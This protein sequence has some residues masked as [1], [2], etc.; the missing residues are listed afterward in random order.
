MDASLDIS[1]KSPLHTKLLERLDKRY[2]LSAERMQKLHTQWMKAED[3][4]VAY[5]PTKDVDALRTAKRENSGIQDYTTIILPYSYSMMM[6]AHSYW[7]SVFLGRS[8]IWQ[9]SGR[10]GESEQQTQALEA[11]MDYQVQVGRQMLPYYFWLL[12]A[13]KFGLGV[14]GEYWCEEQ[15]YVSRNVMMPGKTILGMELTKPKAQLQT[16]VIPGYQG[17]KLF[18]IRPYD[19]FPDPRV[20][21]WDMQRGEFV[22]HHNEVGWNEIYRKAQSGEFI[23]GNCDVLKRKLFDGGT[24]GMTGRVEG[25]PRANLPNSTE[26]VLNL[27]DLGDTGPYGLLTQYVDLVPSEWGVGESSYPEKWVFTSAVQGRRATTSAAGNLKVILGAKPL[28]AYHNKFPASIIQMEPDAYALTTRGMPEVTRPLQR[29][30]DWLLNVHMYNVRNALNIQFLL[31]PGRVVMGDFKNP[32][33]GGGIRLKQAAWGTDPRTV[34]AQMPVQDVTRGNIMDMQYLDQFAQKAL[35][36]NDAIMGQINTG[37]RKTA[38]EV[39]SSSTFGVNRQKTVSEF[40]SASGFDPLAELMV[41]DSQQWYQGD[42]K[43]KIVGDLA[44]MAGPSFMSVKPED[45]AGFFNF[46]PVDGTLP[47]DRFAQ[48]NLWKEIMLAMKQMPQLAMEYDLGKIFAWTAQLAGLKNINQMKL[49]MQSADP[50]KIAA[51]AQAGNIVPLNQATATNLNEPAQI[52]GMG[53]TG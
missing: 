8:P 40:F 46:V 23:K 24:Q 4:F 42:Q 52:P 38:A 17:C 35:G 19:Y 16:E 49:N 51:A 32:L 20:P 33:P 7:T 21:L 36:I 50:N 31:D 37:G 13:A 15:N 11:L 9:F 44:Q 6:S 18:N 53:P 22:G 34:M 10:H 5:A 1:Y 30:M 48:A 2:R 41:S 25:S 14:V 26:D 47:I 3:D 28:G 39:R 45:I 29:A 27:S 43:F 12:D